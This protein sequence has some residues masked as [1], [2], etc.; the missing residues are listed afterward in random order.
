MTEQ[1]Q[2]EMVLEEASASGEENW[3]CPT[4]GRRMIITW[5]PW[6][7]VVLEQGD[8][9]AAH[10]GS[11]GGLKL[12]PLQIMQGNQVVGS[13]VPESSTDDPYLAPWQRW[14]ES[15]DSDDLWNK[16]P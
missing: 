5:R 15:V 7:K 9:Y 13:S 14:L 16:E 6:K 8:Q 1:Q 10:S 2:H 12:G 3:Y 11:K 4:C